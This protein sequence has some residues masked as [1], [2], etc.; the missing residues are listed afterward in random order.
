MIAPATVATASP[1]SLPIAILA[2]FALGAAVL[3][4]V[5]IA[6]TLVARY[7][8]AHS[9]E[10]G[11]VAFGLLFLTTVPI[12]LRF[13]LASI[14]GISVDTIN[15]VTA[16]SELAGLLAILVTIYEPGGQQ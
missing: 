10:A 11:T 4:S 15:I 13:I 2:L 6:Y 16:L 9:S 3:Y 7:R 8:T 5:R 14:G 1:D 12:V